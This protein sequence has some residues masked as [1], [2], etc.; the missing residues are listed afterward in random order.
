MAT[1]T[2]T[3]ALNDTELQDV[4]GGCRGTGGSYATSY[5]HDAKGRTVGYYNSSNELYYWKCTHCGNPVHRDGFYFCD[6]C[7][8]WWLSRADYV[9]HGTEAELIAA[10]G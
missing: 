4:T 3:D 5:V 10:A 6:P 2:N 8:D 7:D 1:E 9:W